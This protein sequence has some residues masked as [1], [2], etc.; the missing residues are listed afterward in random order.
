MRR[1]APSL[2]VFPALAA[3][4]LGVAACGD[5]NP[6]ALPDAVPPPP[7]A[8]AALRCEADVRAG[9]LAC[10]PEGART[11]AGASAVILGAQGVNVR[12]SSSGTS[13]DGTSI[14]R[15]DVRVENLIPQAL[16]TADGSIPA[17]EGVRVFFHDG[18]RATGGSGSVT[19]DNPDGVGSF[20]ASGQPYFQYDGILAPGD[21]TAPKEWRFGVPNTVSTFSFVVY[22]LAPV[23]GEAGWM[24]LSPLAPTLLVGETD[25]IAATVH[26]VFGNVLSSP[27][28]WE[29]SND[30]VA[31]VSSTGVVTS[32]EEGFTWITATSGPHTARVWTFVG[33]AYPE[34]VEFSMSPRLVRTSGA[35]SVT[36]RVA[37]RSEDG[38]GGAMFTLSDPAGTH[39]SCSAGGGGRVSGTMYD[40]VYQCK[41]G[42]PAGLP[43]GTWRVEFVQA[44]SVRNY[45]IALHDT[46]LL[47]A[48][49]PVHLYVRAP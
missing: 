47:D 8:V 5:R 40:G 26:D 29:S 10:R 41:I 48:G 25:S 14:L 18:P 33:S 4:L 7:S 9:T 21:T 42:I 13:Y 6:A 30:T 32:V 23:R 3:V 11:P 35:D 31:T 37:L 46:Y 12:L 43:D 36:L 49:A 2:R 19:V 27:V 15:S 16:G 20:T 24:T 38:I 44:W 1:T 39:R 34:V 45:T 17:P 28:L 22:V